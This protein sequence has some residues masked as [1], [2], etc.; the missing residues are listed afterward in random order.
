ML[1]TQADWLHMAVLFLMLGSVA[2]FLAGV[3][4]VWRPE[5]LAR[6][7]AIANGWVST[8]QMARP[9]GKQL[10]MDHWF[11]R[12]GAF[13]GGALFVGAVYILYTFTAHLTRAEL[14]LTLNKFKLVQPA[15]MES[16]ADTLVL[17]FI[18]AAILAIMVSQFLIF[19]PSVLRDFELSANQ[20]VSLRSSLKPM[21]V[22]RDNLDKLVF[23]NVQLIG[24]FLM[25]A[26]LYTLVML[27]IWLLN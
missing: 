2:G 25:G 14:L 3:L 19:R 10:D 11:Y 8:R 4:L 12:Y 6:I 5:W 13:S 7:S 20:N 15:L 27:A 9:L 24:V 17:L 21:E 22:Q 18:A 1:I 26:S 16:V 23:E